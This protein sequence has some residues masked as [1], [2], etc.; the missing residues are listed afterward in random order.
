[1]KNDFA[2]DFGLHL[3]EL[4]KNKGMTQKQV[5]DLIGLKE[6]TIGG[7]ENNLS[8][9]PSKILMKLA[10]VFGIT[11]DSLLGRDE[12]RMVCVDH[13]TD[14]QICAVELL[15]NSIQNEQKERN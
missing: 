1:M 13:L 9:P 12:R 15:V 2:F 10:N 3:K 4:R 5:A 6:P 14:E 8:M 11:I 7:Y